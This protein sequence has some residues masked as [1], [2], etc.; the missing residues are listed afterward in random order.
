MPLNASERTQLAQSFLKCFGED[1]Q[2]CGRTARFMNDFTV[3]TVNLLASIQ[4]AADTWQPF[5][6]SGL[7]ISA[8][9]AEVARY[10]NLTQT[11]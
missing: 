5:I 9:K 2:M 10:Y 7:T 1:A 6:D 11:T 3:G 4:A 8:W